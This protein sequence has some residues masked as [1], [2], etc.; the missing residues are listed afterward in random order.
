MAIGE[1]PTLLLLAGVA[2]GHI[3]IVFGLFTWG[4]WVARR[5][6]RAFWHR[7]AWMSLVGLALEGLG[8]IVALAIFAGSFGGIVDSPGASEATALALAISRAMNWGV[9]IAAPTLLLYVASVVTFT[10]GSV[11]KAP[12]PQPTS[13]GTA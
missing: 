4:R 6:N 10:I 11:K 8:F 13:P 2:A 7:A 5:H 12:G 3:A 1:L 9:P